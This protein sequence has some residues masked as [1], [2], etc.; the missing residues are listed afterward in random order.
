MFQ[1]NLGFGGVQ[2]PAEIEQEIPSRFRPELEELPE[3]QDAGIENIRKQGTLLARKPGISD[4]STDELSY[5]PSS[6]SLE[7]AQLMDDLRVSYAVSNAYKK[8]GEAVARAR[9]R[10][11]TRALNNSITQDKYQRRKVQSNT[12]RNIKSTVLHNARD[13]LGMGVDL[14]R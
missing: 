7:A 14:Y 5:G 3:M 2:G 8:R 12:Q 11:A 6:R 13:V 9:N 10:Q 4:L 1:F